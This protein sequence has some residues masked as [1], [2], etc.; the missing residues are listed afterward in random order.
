VTRRERIRRRMQSVSD[1][2][3]AGRVVFRTIDLGNFCEVVR[4]SRE[5][6][7]GMDR[8]ALVLRNASRQV[9]TT[10]D[11]EVR[12]EHRDLQQQALGFDP[13]EPVGDQTGY[14][15]TGRWGDAIRAPDGQPLVVHAGCE[16]GLVRR[17]DTPTL[18]ERCGR[19]WTDAQIIAASSL[20][21]V[22]LEPRTVRVQNVTARVCAGQVHQTDAGLLNRDDRRMAY[23]CGI[24]GNTWD[25][26]ELTSARHLEAVGIVSRLIL[27]TEPD[28]DESIVLH[29]L[30]DV[31]VGRLLR[32][33]TILSIAQQIES[34]AYSIDHS[35]TQTPRSRDGH[36]WLQA[37]SPLTGPREAFD[38]LAAA[39]I[40]TRE[41]PGESSSALAPPAR[42]LPPYRAR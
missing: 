8:L 24:C 14:S 23:S 26:A 33:S 42:F 32:G 18:C 34:G 15:F 22:G 16:G 28:A 39:A 31:R 1:L 40:G 3:K 10:L 17:D 38:A 2:V 36:A 37:S 30:A 9:R 21:A 25:M 35:V 27:V 20:A 19:T 7:A 4:T 6:A 13:G 41:E 12:R 5:A 29:E 11:A